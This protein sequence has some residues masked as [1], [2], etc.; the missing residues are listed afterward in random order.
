VNSIRFI[1]QAKVI[2]WHAATGGCSSTV[3]RMTRAISVKERK[4]PDQLPLIADPRTVWHY[5]VTQPFCE[6][7]FTCE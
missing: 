7:R 1:G 5:G 2:A 6:A 3:M 4:K